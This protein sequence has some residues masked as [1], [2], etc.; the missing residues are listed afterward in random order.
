MIQATDSKWWGWKDALAETGITVQ[1][2]CDRYIEAKYKEK[3][4]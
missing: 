4:G 2:I 1:F 3:M